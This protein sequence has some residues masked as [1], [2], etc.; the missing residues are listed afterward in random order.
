MAYKIETIPVPKA[1]RNS[2]PFDKLKVGQSFLETD[3]NRLNS[4]KVAAT[5]FNKN[6]KGHAV[7]SI[8]KDPK[9]YRCFRI[10]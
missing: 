2:F 8:K 7:L 5:A 9:G 3:I 10:K 4:L 1:I 6:N